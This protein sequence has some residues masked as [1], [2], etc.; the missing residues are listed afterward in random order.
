[1]TDLDSKGVIVQC[2]SCG[3]RNRLMYGRLGAETR[4]GKCQTGL[5]APSEP[6]E[7][8]DS[9]AFDATVAQSALPVVVDFWAPWCGPCRSEE[10]TSELQSHSFISYAVF[11]L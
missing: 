3:Q 8:P 5:S 7:I 9:S 11:C 1:M 10:H 4:C 2:P 6:I